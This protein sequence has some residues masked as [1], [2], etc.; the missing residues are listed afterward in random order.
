[1]SPVIPATTKAPKKG[2]KGVPMT[3]PHL[4][5]EI[6]FDL[7][8]AK[9]SFL[10]ELMSVVLIALIPTPEYTAHVAD[11]LG[12]KKQSK[13]MSEMLFVLVS[14]FNCFGSGVHPSTQSL[15]LCILQIR[16]LGSGDN[17]DADAGAGTLFGALAV[18]QAVG[19]AI[20]GVSVFSLLSTPML[21]RTLNIADSIRTSI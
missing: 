11:F 20:L 16:N 8:L 13:R 9:F 6:S 17:T 2:K 18:L 21:T 19:S 15:A 7:S 14:S 3:R 1:M 12:G 4:A 5:K 10:V